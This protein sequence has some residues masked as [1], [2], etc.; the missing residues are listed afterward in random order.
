MRARS[1]VR[2]GGVVVDDDDDAA[3]VFTFPLPPASFSFSFSLL[4]FADDDVDDDDNEREKRLLL[5]SHMIALLCFDNLVPMNLLLCLSR[6][7][8]SKCCMRRM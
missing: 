2:V 3:V 1:T 6:P 4:F 7:Q 5:F 8:D